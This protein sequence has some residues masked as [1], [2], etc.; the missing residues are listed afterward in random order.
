MDGL[1]T[2][3]PLSLISNDD[4]GYETVRQVGGILK[5]N[6]AERPMSQNESSSEHDPNYETLLPNSIVVVPLKNN[7]R[8]LV[9]AG[10]DE[11]EDGYSKIKPGSASVLNTTTTSDSD[12]YSSI[13]NIPN[14]RI[15]TT[16]IAVDEEEDEEPGY[17][18]IGGTAKKNA[19]GYSSIE[20]AKRDRL[21]G[22]STIG[23]NGSVAAAVIATTT[24][25]NSSVSPISPINYFPVTTTSVETTQSSYSSNTSP[26]SEFSSTEV[27]NRNSTGLMLMMMSSSGEGNNNY[28]SLTSEDPNYETVRHHLRI[29][30]NPY[31]VLENELGTPMVDSGREEKPREETDHVEKGDNRKVSPSDSPEV[32]DYF[33][34]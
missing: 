30:E 33:Q 17:S 10:D 31:E 3:E 20:E 7:P 5:L 13:T 32:G 14:E 18:Q 11:E 2:E 21:E 16:A 28:E 8:R 23:E 34:V 22:Y 26:S 9:S 1:L 27:M 4:P 29:T 6:R 12:G 15:I 19:H 25:S 24:N